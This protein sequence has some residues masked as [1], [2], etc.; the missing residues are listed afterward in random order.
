MLKRAFDLIFA[1]AA[2]IVLSVPLI[3][4]IVDIKFSSPGPVFYRGERVGLRGRRFRILKFRTMVVDADRLGGSSTAEGDPRITRIGGFLRRYKLDELPQFWNVL[5]GDMSV[6]G[7]RP[8]VAWAVDLYTPEERR[9][10]DVRPGITDDASIKFRD[11]AAILKG[12]TDPDRAYLEL[13]APEKI[14]LGLHYVNT[15]TLRTDLRIIF[16]TMFAA[17]RPGRGT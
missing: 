10:L 7:P 2:L 12:A 17:A 6:V 1:T 8:Q 13:I 9:L 14:R 3:L 16:M 4:I 5:I 11:E 15:H